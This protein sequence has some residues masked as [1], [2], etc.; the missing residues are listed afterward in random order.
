MGKECKYCAA[1]QIRS[2]LRKA[3]ITMKKML[4]SMGILIGIIVFSGCNT[5][6][7]SYRSGKKSFENGNYEE[8]AAYF[9]KATKDNPEHGEYYVNFG[10]SLIALGQYK[11]AIEAFD[12]V[13]MDKDILVVRQNNKRSLRGKGIAH[14]YLREYNLAI[15]EFQKA[16][17][18]NELTK[19]NVDILYY[20]GNAYRNNGLYEEAVGVYTRIL[21]ANKDDAK[22]YAE[23]AYSYQCLGDYEQSL[24]D[25]NSAIAGKPNRYDYYFGKYQLLQEQGEL[26]KAQEVLNEAAKI[27]VKTSEDKFNM[28]KLHYYQ[29]DYEA[30]LM[31]LNESFASGFVQAYYFIGEIYRQQGNPSMAVYYYELYINEG[32]PELPHAYNQAA[33]CLI[34]LGNVEEALEYVQEG[35]KYHHADTL[36]VLRMNEIIA[37]EKLGKFE[38]AQEK[39]TEYRADYPNADELSREAE[40]IDSRLIELEEIESR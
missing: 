21:D 17:K 6:E 8:A 40:F 11:E 29:G 19:L 15:E 18:M 27:P 37:Y 5:A 16:L 35:M 25:Y 30:A 4:L 2:L 10:M 31:E 36:A 14:Y 24:S 13:Y 3:W 38:L 9:A 7:S 23:R 22:A 28:A 34:A 33:A 39:M 12:T 26:A 1:A 32:K 20:M